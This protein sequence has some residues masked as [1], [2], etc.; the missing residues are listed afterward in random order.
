MD[1]QWH[2][3][4]HMQIMCTSHRTENHASASAL[5]IYRPDALPETNQDMWWMVSCVVVFSRECVYVTKGLVISLK[6]CRIKWKQTVCVLRFLRERTPSSRSL[7]VSCLELMMRVDMAQHQS[8]CGITMQQLTRKETGFPSH[9][10][11]A[12]IDSVFSC[13][14]RNDCTLAVTAQC[15]TDGFWATVCKTVRPMLSDRCLSVCPV[16]LWRSCTVAK[17]LDGS[18]WNLACR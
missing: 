17:R 9:I 13:M 8:S 4:G 7:C 3:L 6:T 10:Q 11:V 18:T 2:Q 1:W 16:C 15:I 14:Y 12:H 5:N